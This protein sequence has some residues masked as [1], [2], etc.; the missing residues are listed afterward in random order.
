MA[1]KVTVQDIA[2]A[3]GLSRNTIS[4]ALNNHPQI[5]EGTKKRVIQKAAEMKYKNYSFMNGGNIALLTRG[6]INAISFYSETIKGMETS[7]ALK[8]LI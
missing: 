2:D 4:K 3:M 8:A 7:C 1:E 5:P 6:D